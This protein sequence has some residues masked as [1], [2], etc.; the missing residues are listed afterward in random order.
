MT[1]MPSVLADPLEAAKHYGRIVR[2]LARLMEDRTD[3]GYIFRIDLR[4]RPDPG[5][6]PVAMSLDAALTYY[7][8][9]GQNWERA[10]WIKA[11]PCAGDKGVGDA[12]LRQLAP[13][14]WRKHL[15]FATISDIQAMKRQINI[16]RKVGEARLPGH[17]VKL[18]RGGIREIE[19]FAQTQQLIA[20]GR[21]TALRVRPTVKAL[22]A[23]A[24]Y[25][26][27]AE[28]TA[29]ELT[30]AYWFL[31]AVENRVQMQR[32]EQ[33][34]TLP[35]SE[36]GLS[37]IAT[38]L[39]LDLRAFEARYTSALD[40]VVTY[41]A[42]LFTEGETLASDIGDLV[43]TGSDDDP[44][45]LE[46]LSALGF[47]NPSAASAIIR[48]W[49]YGSYAA[50]RASAARAHLTELLP[51]LLTIISASRSADLALQRFDHFLSRFP[52]GIQLFALLRTHPNLTRLLVAFM[53][54]APRLAEAV[55]HRAHVMDG[56]IDPAFA[57]DVTD[58]EVL[59]CRVREFLD[60]ARSYE[61]R[62]D[63]A[64]II[65]QEQK[66][67]ISAAFVSGTI[68]AARA[69]A[70]FTN[71]AETLLDRLLASV[72][73]EF[74][75]RHGIVPGAEMGLLGFGKMASCEMTASSDLDF[76][77]LYQAP[78]DVEESDGDRPLAPS[79]YFARLTQRL[80]AALS[81]PTAEG[82]L[83]EADMRLRPSG[84]AGPL[85]TSIAAF[86]EY[87][88]S[89]AWTWERL[90]LSRARMV[91][92]DECFGPTVDY[93]IEE[94]LSAPRDAA[95]TVADVQDMRARIARDRK[96]R[97]PFD[98]KLLPGGL[99]DIEFVAQSAQLLA[100]RQLDL[101]HASP[102]EIL[103]RMSEKAIMPEAAELV[104]IHALYTTLLQAMSICLV[105]PFSEE[106]W[107]GAFRELLLELTH[108]PDFDRLQLALEQGQKR[109]QEIAAS[110]YERAV[111]F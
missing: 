35:E 8:A 27:I 98:L 79:Q 48:K 70:Q 85:A 39:G 93:A 81:A 36:E 111:T 20:G 16:V 59:T 91:A 49:H 55:I 68:D 30:D 13:F 94:A 103:A 11:R 96:P 2:D 31:R 15:D 61:D 29:N 51:S 105:N 19:F 18:G 90:A 78:S 74:A 1:P 69:G 104:E 64:R 21:E 75:K 54:S 37:Q 62:I 45:T 73:E 87:Q 53:S 9:R 22:A 102:P 24:D 89:H 25:G 3:Q 32:D 12:F 56:L 28:E 47:E 44:G 60:E 6:T 57:E 82:V 40:T 72:R 106:S 97:H 83:Y 108:F 26:W 38:L 80:V 66:F 5:S 17:N 76:I 42:E 41:Y 23:L 14:I 77:M 109:V 110:W 4:L 58:S 100:R 88:Q 71:L 33:T 43:F 99:I 92:G 65:G 46:T 84:N 63:R 34:H 10:A 101:P 67:L 52:S 107:T 7:E 50:T 95:R 86:R